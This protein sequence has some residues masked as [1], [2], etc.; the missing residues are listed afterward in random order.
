MSR[1]INYAVR[2]HTDRIA[3]IIWFISVSVCLWASFNC[4]PCNF[5][6]STYASEFSCEVCK[7][8]QMANEKDCPFLVREQ[9]DP[10]RRPDHLGGGAAIGGSTVSLV[11]SGAEERRH[12]L[13]EPQ[14][15]IFPI[16]YIISTSQEASFP[17]KTDSL[18]HQGFTLWGEVIDLFT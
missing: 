11:T 6:L 10:K 9:R 7:W 2:K 14:M 16:N 13:W 4:L 1:W 17:S 3:V 8:Q 12:F 18:L 15:I 5:C